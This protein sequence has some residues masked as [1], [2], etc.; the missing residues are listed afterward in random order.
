MC[1]N[2]R[3]GAWAP[4]DSIMA[5][6]ST[7]TSSSPVPPAPPREV[8]LELVRAA[9]RGA[10]EQ[11]GG[12]VNRLVTVLLDLTAAGIDADAAYRRTRAGNLLKS[13]SYAFIHLAS[14]ALE[15][16][17]EQAAAELAPSGKQ[18]AG[19][20]SLS[21]VPMEVMDTRVA[22][23]ALCR[24]FEIAHAEVLASLCVRFGLLLGRDVLRPG[25]NPLRPE[26]FLGAIH[27]A[28]CEFEPDSAAHAEKSTWVYPAM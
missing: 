26:V 10:G 28:W 15:R 13:N 8:L 21:L 4:K 12:L 14:Q 7:E 5:H 27:G 2:D 20:A 19:L 9:A 22:F 1:N 24:P 18:D 11:L 6:A 17:L 23:G 16:Q 3:E 25:Q